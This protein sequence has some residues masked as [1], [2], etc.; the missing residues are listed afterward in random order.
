[1][2][3]IYGLNHSQSSAK[4][5]GHIPPKPQ[6]DDKFL[7]HFGVLGMKWGR[8]KDKEGSGKAKP[9]Y[10]PTVDP[11]KLGS[12]IKNMDKTLHTS[13]QDAAHEIAGMLK[14]R[15]GYEVTTV[16]AIA[17]KKKFKNYIAYVEAGA[18]SGN[19]KSKG[20]IHVQ[21]RDLNPELKQLENSGWFGKGAGNVRSVMTHETA[22]SMFHAE[23]RVTGSVFNVKVTGGNFE[24]RQKAFND[25]VKT[26]EADGI[27]RKDVAGNISGY[28]K[29][30]MWRE[31]AEAEMFSQYHW[32]PNPP[33]FIKTWGETLHREMGIDATPFREVVDN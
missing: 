31:E 5:Y 13:T 17:D 25:A 20:T 10:E 11:I 8:R 14:Q 24:A 26:A 22:H 21:P 32:S 27:K 29:A 23:E 33:R 28:A 12:P 15:Y 4:L 18:A 3:K 30:A 7:Q 6:L 16:S 19:S 9:T 2:N 1:M